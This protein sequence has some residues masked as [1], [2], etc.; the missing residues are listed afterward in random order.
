[1][2]LAE[3]RLLC[4]RV[5]RLDNPLRMDAYYFGFTPTGEEL[6]DRILSAVASAGKA[7]HHT[8]DWTEAIDPYEDV[9]RGQTCAEWIQY[10]AND[11]AAVIKWLPALIDAA[12]TLGQIADDCEAVARSEIV[13]LG[14]RR[15]WLAV[16]KVAHAALA[17]LD[18]VERT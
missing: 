3:L 16:A 14:E 8:E 6:I 15:A 17:R 7:Y 10:A 12:Q 2:T 11:A 9:F 18:E 4:E 13:D 5:Q 1:M